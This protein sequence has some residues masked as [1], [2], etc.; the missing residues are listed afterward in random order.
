MATIL[1]IETS[2][3]NCSVSIAKDNELLCLVEEADEGYAHGE[4]L[5]Q[6]IDWCAEGAGISLKKI[7]AICVSK[8][9][10]SYTGLRIGVSSAKGL[11]YG[12]DAKLLAIN[13]LQ[14]LAQSQINKGYDLIIPLI[15]ARRM[16]VYTAT[17]D[18]AGNELKSTEAKVIEDNSF[19][20]YKGK[21]IVFVGDGAD[22][23]KEALAYLEA[24]FV[25][26]FPSAKYMV[27][28]ANEKFNAEKF[29]DVA[30]FEPFY[31]K[32]FVALKKKTD[33]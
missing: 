30:Y 19:E 13:S 17:F 20:E 29:E 25:Q 4:K 28:V 11:A 26:I 32:D 3:K 2:T 15:D 7:D 23:C 14:I 21:K 22:K 18:G 1:N 6:F 8:G 31:L 33:K 16:E 9:P 24:D 5:H 27:E 10:G 12:L